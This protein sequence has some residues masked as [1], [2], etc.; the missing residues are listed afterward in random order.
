LPEKA[1]T[2]L[3]FQITEI[4]AFNAS[5]RHSIIDLARLKY[6]WSES[7]LLTEEESDTPSVSENDDTES[8]A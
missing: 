8:H 6:M 3:V 4:Q 7:A 5:L 2:H 1:K